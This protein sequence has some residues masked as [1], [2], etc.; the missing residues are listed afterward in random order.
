MA[1]V[2]FAMGDRAGALKWSEL[3]LLRYPLIDIPYDTMIRKQHERFRSGPL[4]E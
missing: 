3:S 1:E 2:R 4:P